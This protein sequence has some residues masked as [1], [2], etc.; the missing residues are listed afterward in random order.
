MFQSSAEPHAFT[1]PLRQ[2]ILGEL[3][4]SDTKRHV[5]AMLAGFVLGA[6]LLAIIA[7]WNEV[8]FYAVFYWELFLSLCA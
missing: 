4:R 6:V 1:D 7:L 2:E 8:A 5:G 3:S